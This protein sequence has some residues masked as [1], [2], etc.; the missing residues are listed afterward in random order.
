MGGTLEAKKHS[1][2]EKNNNSIL[3]ALEF[4]KKFGKHN[5][6]SKVGWVSIDRPGERSPE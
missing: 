5:L 6:L 1:D 4:R 2:Q 3:A